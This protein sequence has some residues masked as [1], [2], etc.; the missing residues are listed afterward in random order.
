MNATDH[1]VMN[2]LSQSIV[3][4]GAKAI[5]IASSCAYSSVTASLRRLQADGE[6]VKNKD[7]TYATHRVGGTTKPLMGIARMVVKNMRNE[8]PFTAY[9][10]AKAINASAGATKNACEKLVE[11]GHLVRTQT[12]K[13]RQYRVTGAK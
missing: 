11:S 6:I 9:E 8:P 7:N 2:A 3:P 13:P 10:A 1:K 5:A 4:L 12:K